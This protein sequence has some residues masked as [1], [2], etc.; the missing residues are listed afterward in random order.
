VE[1]LFAFESCYI[2]KDSNVGISEKQ[3]EASDSLK[4]AM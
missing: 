1:Q 4:A 2:S 3:Q